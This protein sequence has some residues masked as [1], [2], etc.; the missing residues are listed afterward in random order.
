ML[1]EAASRQQSPG[2]RKSRSY[3]GGSAPFDARY[4]LATYPDVANAYGPTNYEAAAVHYLPSG[5]A[6]GRRGA[7]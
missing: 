3:P 7:P 4:Y 6:E 1:N 5:R 2:S